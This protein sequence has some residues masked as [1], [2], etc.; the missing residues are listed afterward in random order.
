[1]GYR[2]TE[3]TQAPFPALPL[4][5]PQLPQCQLRTSN[6]EPPGPCWLIPSEMTDSS[7]CLVFTFDL[8]DNFHFYGL[9]LS[10]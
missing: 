3:R 6:S 10:G 4:G 2:A 8:S 7:C 1:M 9:E 5:H